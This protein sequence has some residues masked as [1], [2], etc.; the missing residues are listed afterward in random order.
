MFGYDTVDGWLWVMECCVCGNT[1]IL[2]LAVEIPSILSFPT[3]KNAFLPSR[4]SIFI[5]KNKPRMSTNSNRTEEGT[6][7]IPKFRFEVNLGSGLDNV[8]FQEVTGLDVESAIIEYRKGESRVFSPIKMPGIGKHG[9]LTLK[10]GVFVKDNT[11]WEWY[12]KISNNE[13]ANGTITI[14]L[15]EEGGKVV[16]QWLLHNALPIKITGTDLKSTGN[17]V[18]VE[19]IEIGHEGLTI[20]NS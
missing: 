18:A 6:W 10:K 7:P 15:L 9:N 1:Q 8:E 13:I 14:K 16:M 12:K 3:T 4:M 17:E 19:A 2:Y 5:D 11:F 20:S